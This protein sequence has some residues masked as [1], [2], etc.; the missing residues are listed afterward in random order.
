MPGPEGR[1]V[2]PRAR[3]GWSPRWVVASVLAHAVLVAVWD[4]NWFRGPVERM[5]SARLH[6]QVTISGDLNVNLWSWQPSATVDGISIANPAWAGLA[7]PAP[8]YGIHRCLVDRALDHGVK[9]AAVWP[10]VSLPAYI[11][12]AGRTPWRSGRGGF[13]AQVMKWAD[14]WMRL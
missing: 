1:F 12:D 8:N 7:S 2:F 10:P 14:A 11:E 4:W 13:A 6:R 3:S 5:A 9:R